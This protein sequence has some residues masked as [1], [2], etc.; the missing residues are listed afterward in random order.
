MVKKDF[1]LADLNA[2]LI[3]AIAK[4]YDLSIESLKQLNN[5]KGDGVMAG[6]LLLV[7]N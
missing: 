1:I 7:S 6:Q 5:I 3:F 2:F 4:R